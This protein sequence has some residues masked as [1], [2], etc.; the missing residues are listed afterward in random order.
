MRHFSEIF[1]KRTDD[2]NSRSAKQEKEATWE[3]SADVVWRLSRLPHTY[4][5]NS[6]L[7]SIRKSTIME[8][9]NKDWTKNLLVGN[10]VSS[11]SWKIA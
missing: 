10:Y 4:V 6:I 11:N 3:S 8:M 9:M 7:D 1:D 5:Y 2:K